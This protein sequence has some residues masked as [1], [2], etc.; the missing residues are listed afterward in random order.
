MNARAL[1]ARDRRALRIAALVAIPYLAW[2]LATGPLSRAG[3]RASAAVEAARTLLARE[4]AIV[5]EEREYPARRAEGRRALADAAP[6]LITGTTAGA[7]SAA[8]I[9]WLQGRARTTEVRISEAAPLADAVDAAGLAATSVRLAGDGNLED[10]MLLLRALESGEKL[11]RITRLDVERA[12]DA[13][14]DFSLDVT[15]Y[16]VVEPTA[17]SRP[18]T[19]RA[20][21][22]R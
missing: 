16:T 13:S 19:A 11:L 7:R 14:L 5:A 20:M 3:A 18:A 10:V 12:G 2:S 21:V 8:L 1:T 6:R 9:A 22:G 15:G 4:L 17:A